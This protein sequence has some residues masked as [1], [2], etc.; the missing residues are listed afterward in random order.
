MKTSIIIQARMS[1]SRLPGKVLKTI[2][3]IPIIELIIKRLK[4]SKLKDDIIVATSNLKDNKPL[5]NFLK[6]K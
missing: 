1:S 6:R 5:L 2:D 4:K 3:N